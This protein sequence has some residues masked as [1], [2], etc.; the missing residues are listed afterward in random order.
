MHAVTHEVQYG[1]VEIE[2]KRLM[3]VNSPGFCDLAMK[4]EDIDRELR[5]CVECTS[6]GLHAFVLVTGIGRFTNDDHLVL[7]KCK[8][9]FGDHMKE[10]LIVLFSRCDDIERKGSSIEKFLSEGDD[11][12]MNILEKAKN[13]YIALNDNAP[14]DQK[15]RKVVK[16][17]YMIQRLMKENKGKIFTNK[18]YQE[19][20]E[21]YQKKKLAEEMKRKEKEEKR[22]HLQ[23]ITR[24]EAALNM[25]RE[26]F[27]K[28]KAEA[29]AAAISHTK[30]LEKKYEKEKKELENKVRE[31]EEEIE[32]E[33]I[34]RIMINLQDEY[35]RRIRSLKESND[36][37]T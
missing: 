23:E 36:Q 29:E 4:E 30:L 37:I 15:Q 2:G 19:V 12:L 11:Q 16:L 34:G 21:A 10:Y 33:K 31:C 26:L 14:E 32:R 3:V 13:R 8:E 5:R 1:K 17:K 24:R 18:M 35:Q 25:E 28:R 9:K 7:Q 22:K 20:E 27:E 6:P